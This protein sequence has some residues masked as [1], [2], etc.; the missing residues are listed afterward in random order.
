MKAVLIL[1][2]ENEYF[3][4]LLQKKS[5][6]SFLPF[7][8]N[9]TLLSI[10][11]S[12]INSYFSKDKIFVCC[13]KGE[14]NLVKSFCTDLPDE[15]IIIEPER[16]SHSLSILFASTFIEKSYP[17]SVVIF[18]PVNFKNPHSLKIKNWLLAIQEIC[19]ANWIVIPS[20]LLNREESII[21]YL[22]AGKIVNHIKGVDFFEVENFFLKEKKKNK[23]FGKHGCITKII[24]GKFKNIIE[25]F[26]NLSMEHYIYKTFNNILNLTDI[27][28]RN[29]TE[30]YNEIKSNNLV[31]EIFNNT[32]NFLTIFLDRKLE[33]LHNWNSF[34][35]ENTPDNNFLQGKIISNNC[36]KIICFNYD[37][38]DIIV[39]SVKNLVIVKKNGIVAIKNIL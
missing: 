33:Y 34:F 10:F 6:I 31:I 30:L 16:Y 37:D 7:S 9:S 20:F 8:I 38:E 12:W 29:I 1:G 23:L 24:C 14:E 39:D 27:S 5:S 18:I 35:T 2:D 32:K 36:E 17:E 15:N 22:E 11:Y 26:A 28:W 3:Y 19:Q 25:C 13:K 21:P 4:P